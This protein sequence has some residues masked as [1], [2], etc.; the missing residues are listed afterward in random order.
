MRIV[1]ARQ[2]LLKTIK[3][4]SVIS[5]QHVNL[6]GEYDFTSTANTSMFNFAF[7]LDKIKEL[8]VS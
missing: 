7:E 8:K 4:S 3:E 2:L 1:D 5:W 6:H